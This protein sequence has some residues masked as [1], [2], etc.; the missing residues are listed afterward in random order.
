MKA[1][2]VSEQAAVESSGISSCALDR[3]GTVPN[4]FDT[5]VIA[6]PVIASPVITPLMTETPIAEPSVSVPRLVAPPVVLPTILPPPVIIHREEEATDIVT[7]MLV[8][9]VEESRHAQGTPPCD[10][11]SSTANTVP[12][13]DRESVGVLS[14][15]SQIAAAIAI[16]VLAVSPKPDFARLFRSPDSTADSVSV[17]RSTTTPSSDST[18]LNGSDTAP[19]QAPPA[20]NSP[21]LTSSSTSIPTPITATP[22]TA[23]QAPSASETSVSPLSNSVRALEAFLHRAMVQLDRATPPALPSAASDTSHNGTSQADSTTIDT[24]PAHKTDKDSRSVEGPTE[25]STKEVAAPVVSP[26][27]NTTPSDLSPST[28]APQPQPIA[29]SPSPPVV[30]NS[31]PAPGNQ[32]NR[33]DNS[34]SSSSDATLSSSVKPLPPEHFD[35]SVGM[36]LQL[37]PAGEFLMG[38]DE[39]ADQLKD[40]GIFADDKVTNESPR[41]LVKITKPFYLGVYEV[42]RKQFASFVEETGY[43]TDAER[44]GKGAKGFDL[45]E[46]NLKFDTKY[47]W[48]NPGWMQASDHPVVN[49]S[50][51]DAV[52][53]CNWL[54]RTEGRTECYSIEGTR[55]V[56]VYGDGYRLPREAEWEY[57]CRADTRTRYVSGDHPNSLAGFG[58]VRDASYERAASAGESSQSFFTFDDRW[59]FTSR[60]GEFKPNRWGLYDM[61]GNVMEWCQD[62]FYEYPHG[63]VTDPKGPMAGTARAIRGGAW[64][65]GGASCFRTANRESSEPDFASCLVGFRVVLSQPRELTSP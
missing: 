8:P 41:H 17:Q 20:L 40:A 65:C 35:N 50:W 44:N 43:R 15:T 9:L 38:S 24:T 63:I 23:V 5:E 3:P 36:R 58:N 26:L 57:A 4:L 6:P 56:E 14:H 59:A 42:T 51:N 31:Q 18:R 47:H 16:L 37:I 48:R 21:A 29:D 53:F 2:A 55:V 60:C 49:V 64:R 33:S 62:W 13:R 10:Q 39:S 52:A 22:S 61:T 45:V 11:I 32:V 28:S 1:P 30:A 19:K 12:L 34:V 7:P 46:K 25:E 27:T 54:S